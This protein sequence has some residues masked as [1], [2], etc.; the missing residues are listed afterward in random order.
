MQEFYSKNYKMTFETINLNNNSIEEKIVETITERYIETNSIITTEMLKKFT[1]CN[2]SNLN[3]FSI[4]LYS[5][6]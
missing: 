3:N 6:F 5:H 2:N 4:K 1:I